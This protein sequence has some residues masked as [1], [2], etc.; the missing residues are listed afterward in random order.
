MKYCTRG[1]RGGAGTP[2]WSLRF[3]WSREEGEEGFLVRKTEGPGL[4]CGHPP[5]PVSREP[6][7]CLWVTR[8]CL[9]RSQGELGGLPWTSWWGHVALRA[10]QGQGP[11]P[12]MPGPVGLRS[13][14]KVSSPRGAGLL[15]RPGVPPAPPPPRPGASAQPPLPPSISPAQRLQ[16]RPGTPSRAAGW[17]PSSGQRPGQRESEMTWNIQELKSKHHCLIPTL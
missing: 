11:G 6:R 10:P 3:P 14:D 4:G 16:E 2:S 12:G 15:L 13:R 7:P 1:R 17:S 8:E 5:I 9:L